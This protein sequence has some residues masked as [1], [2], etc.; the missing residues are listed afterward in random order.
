MDV[1]VVDSV[2]D[3]MFLLFVQWNQWAGELAYRHG[4][5]LRL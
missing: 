1:L 4:L 2:G 3:D 5:Q